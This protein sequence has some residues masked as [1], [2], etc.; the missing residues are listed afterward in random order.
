VN[1]MTRLE[2]TG[3]VSDA[4]LSERDV[5]LFFERHPPRRNFQSE[6]RDQYRR[7]Q[8]ALL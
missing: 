5:W 2:I 6:R 1:A 7:R 4:L 3:R 8:I